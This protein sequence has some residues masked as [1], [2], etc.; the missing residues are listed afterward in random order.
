MYIPLGFWYQEEYQNAGNW[1][2]WSKQIEITQWNLNLNKVS[3]VSTV[4]A[5]FIHYYI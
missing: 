2:S 3:I 4:S 1:P 5:C